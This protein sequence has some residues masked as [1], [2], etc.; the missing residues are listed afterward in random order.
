MNRR[1]KAPHRKLTLSGV[2]EALEHVI[3]LRMGEMV[4]VISGPGPD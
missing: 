1:A 4:E 2:T 3:V